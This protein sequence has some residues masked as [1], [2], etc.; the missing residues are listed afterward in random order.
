MKRSGPGFFFFLLV[1]AAAITLACGSERMAESISISPATADAQ[2]FANG[3]VQFTATRYFNKQP[4]PVTPL[5][6]TWGVCAQAGN[7]DAVTVSASGL[8]QCAPGATGTYGI[9]A[10]VQNPSHGVCTVAATCGGGCWTVVGRAQ[11]TC[12]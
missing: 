1:L 8:A 12:P 11:L 5:T 3:Q 4:S 2:N 9:Y 10:N 7:P 6:A